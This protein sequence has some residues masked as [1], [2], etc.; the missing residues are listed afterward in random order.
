MEELDEMKEEF[1]LT[2]AKMMVDLVVVK[3][4]VEI[5]E[6]MS[7]EGAF[8]YLDEYNL[9]GGN[10]PYDPYAFYYYIDEKNYKKFLIEWV[11]RFYNEK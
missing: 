8:V 11:S 10:S 7:S 4:I 2:T 1:I 9:F 5:I 3:D 6:Y